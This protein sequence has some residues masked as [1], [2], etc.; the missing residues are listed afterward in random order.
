MPDYGFGPLHPSATT[1]RPAQDAD[2][3]G[4]QT[5]FKD[6]SAPGARDGTLIN[7]SFL[8]H[9][10]G[11]LRYLVQQSGVVFGNA[12]EVDTFVHDAVRALIQA[13]IAAQPAYLQGVTSDSTLTGDGT[14]LSP[15][16]VDTAVLA[17]TYAT[18][19]DVQNA[20]A[21]LVNSAP[22]VLDTLYEL[23]DAI[24]NDPNFLAT[25]TAQL[26][27]KLSAAANLSDVANVSAARSNLG[28]AIGVNVQAYSANLAS[29][30]GIAPASKLD[31]SAVSAFG[32]TLIDDADAATARTTLG[33]VIGTNVQAYSANLAAWSALAT[34]AKQDALGFTPVNKAG[35][36]MTGALTTDGL[37]YKRAT[38]LA[39]ATDLNTITDAGFYSGDNLT[40]A[41]FGAA[42]SFH[43]Q[44]YRSDAD[45]NNVLQIATGFDV[46]TTA[47]RWR[48]GGTWSGWVRLADS[49]LE[50]AWSAQQYSP[51]ATLTDAANI[52]W[53]VNAAQKAKVTLGGNR[54]MNAVTGAVEGATYLLWVIQD[55]GGNRT[56]S[57]T[58]SGAGSF[59]FGTD[60]A[61]TLTTT[62]SRAD[63]LA[64][65]AIS[66]G[67]TLKLR[68]AGIK[69]GF[70]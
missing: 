37:T 32:L 3:F 45:A 65:E 56:L 25:I 35:D 10:I 67:G 36:T 5:W 44:V 70:A 34:S 50:N 51:L 4:A 17:G 58:T 31:A 15:L 43:I 18:H 2:A 69:K 26:N 28:I 39:D 6:A 55:G 30:S 33:L 7:A 52:A 19:L 27:G 60:G 68:F 42:T 54:T 11:N 46:G 16:G 24:G 20:I 63:L 53:P 29:W 40:N 1:N 59:D 9:I 48:V 12:H 8:N 38:A 22:G 49:W 64:F 13:A 23:A 61:P 41:P 14:A 47:R 57:W 66:I 21:A 62:G